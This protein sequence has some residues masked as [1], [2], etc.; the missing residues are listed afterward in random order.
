MFK[1]LSVVDTEGKQK[2]EEMRKKLRDNERIIK[3][4]RKRRYGEKN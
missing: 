4:E 1:F 3:E 2:L